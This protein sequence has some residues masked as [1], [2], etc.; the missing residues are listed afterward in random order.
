MATVFEYH[1]CVG[2]SILSMEDA[3]R[4]AVDAVAATRKIAWF[5]VLSTRGRVTESNELEYQVTVRFGCKL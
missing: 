1:E 4:Q 5:E 2:I 3:I